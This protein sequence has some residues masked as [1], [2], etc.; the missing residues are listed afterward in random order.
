MVGRRDRSSL[1]TGAVKQV[2]V[3]KAALTMAGW[4]VAP[5]RGM[6]CFVDADWPLFGG[7]FSVGEIEVLR[8]AQVADGVF[9]AAAL[10]VGQTVLVHAVLASHFPPA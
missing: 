2:E 9:G 3:V 7:S 4:G 6:L 5:V 8:P 1:V 10:S